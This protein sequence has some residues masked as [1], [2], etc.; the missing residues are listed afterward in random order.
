[1]VVS[2]VLTAIP[3]SP[4]A[5]PKATAVPDAEKVVPVPLTNLSACTRNHFKTPEP[6]FE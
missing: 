5:N 3:L 1:M 2:P 6:V 4:E